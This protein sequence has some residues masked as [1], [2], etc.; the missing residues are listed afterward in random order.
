MPKVKTHKGAA[1]RIRKTGTGKFTFAKAFKRHKAEAKTGKR[2]RQL[3]LTA[4]AVRAD[5]KRLRI[6]LPYNN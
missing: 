2:R 6:M 1:K 5:E 3:R 4:V